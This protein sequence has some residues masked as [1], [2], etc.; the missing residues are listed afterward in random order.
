MNDGN[1]TFCA[2]VDLEKAFDWLNRDLLLLKLLKYRIDGRMFNAIK[3][4]LQGTESCILLNKSL[5][6]N[7]FDILCGV[8]QGDTLSPTLFS[9]FIND[10]V[11]ELKENGPT[12]NINN[13][14]LNCLLY[15]DDMVI[16]GD[17]P[18]NLQQLLDKL[19]TW[20]NKWRL[21]VNQ[22]KTNVVHFRTSRTRQTDQVFNFGHFELETVSR[23][24]YLGVILDENLSYNIC[25][26]ALADSAGRA[27]GA[28]IGKFKTL[29]NVGYETFTKLYEA[30]VKP[31][32]EYCCG[33]W[34]YIRG[35]ELDQIQN[36]AM[37]YY[38]GVHKFAPNVGV[39]GEMGWLSPKLSRNL[40]LARF[41]NRLMD[42][43]NNRLTKVIFIWDYGRG[44]SKWNSEIQKLFNYVEL[45]NIYLQQQKCDVNLLK[46]K[47]TEKFII[48]WKDK[49]SK[50]P[51]LRTYI[52]FKDEFAVEEYVK[53]EKS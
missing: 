20:C 27:L 35:P 8:R 13:F 53:F 18:N 52:T 39:E 51:K 19:H 10:L 49:I 12:L 50:K 31:I 21:K 26:S 9:L 42:M 37:R 2:F 7:W 30:G 48:E 5:Q 36:R 22:S 29:K 34:G 14:K 43:E 47:L 17:S 11:K 41:W 23:Y 38:L 6:T 45:N 1:S 46:E 24:K 28:I 44:R 33:V 25:A 16:I 15:A 3:S 32:M 40:G 4:L